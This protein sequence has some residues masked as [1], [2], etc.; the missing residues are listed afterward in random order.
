MTLWH[1]MLAWGAGAKRTF[2]MEAAGLRSQTAS[3]D[4]TSNARSNTVPRSSSHLC[5]QVSEDDGLC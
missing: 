5:L 1:L 3:V 2:A 4:R